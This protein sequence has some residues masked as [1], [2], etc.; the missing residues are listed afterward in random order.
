[1]PQDDVGVL[2]RP[3]GLRPRRQALAAGVLG[4]VVAGGAQPVGVATLPRT[5]A[6][7]LDAL[8]GDV[9]LRDALGEEAICEFIAVKRGE[10]GSYMESV[11]A[12]EQRT[13]LRR[14]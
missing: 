5:L 3:V 13:Y 12:W 14:A 9:L 2:Q 1:V 11:S 6:D 4:R 8:E 7:A 10:W